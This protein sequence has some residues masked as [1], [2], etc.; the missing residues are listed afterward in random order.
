MSTTKLWAVAFT[1]HRDYAVLLI[2]AGD[3]LYPKQ[4]LGRLLQL[5]SVDGAVDLF[6]VLVL[7]QV[8]HRISRLDFGNCANLFSQARLVAFFDGAL[9]FGDVYRFAQFEFSRLA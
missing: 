4:F 6:A 5:G 2:P 8:G 7:E 9:L 1:F 3:F